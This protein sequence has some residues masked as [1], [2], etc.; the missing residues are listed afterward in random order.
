MQKYNTL[1]QHSS[2]LD[3]MDYEY[4]K[5]NCDFKKLCVSKAL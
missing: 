1:L 3:A 4:G 2:S 5:R